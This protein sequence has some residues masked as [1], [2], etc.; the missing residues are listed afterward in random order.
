MKFL[1]RTSDILRF[2]QSLKRDESQFIVIY[3]RRRIGKSTLI[4]KVLDFS[5]GDL[6]Y[7]ADNTS[8][9]NQR[10]LLSNMVADVIEGFN[11][12][13]YPNWE[14]FFRALNRLVPRRI[15][16]C[17]DEFPYMVKTCPSLPSTL[18]KLLD[19][20]S[21]NFDLIICGSSQQLMQGLVLDS[22]E[23]LY[24]RANEII[25][26]APIPPQFI[27][28]ALNCNA[29]T[30]VEEYAVWGGIPRY[31]ELRNDYPDL[32]SAI[33]NILFSPQGVLVDEPQRL[34]R[35]DMRDTVQTSTIMTVIGNG[36][37]R[38]S[39]I[40]ARTGKDTNHITEPIGK[41]KD[42]GY[43]YRDLPWGEDE[44]KSKKGLYKIS[45]PFLAFHFRFVVPYRSYIEIQRGETVMNIV[46]S[47][48]NEHVGDIWE[49]LCRNYVSGNTVNG[50][51]YQ[52]A[53]RWW[54]KV[55]T[56]ETNK[57]GAMVELDVVAES[58]DKKHILIGECKWTA[59]EDAARLIH[60][61]ESI[62]KGLPFVKKHS[63]HYVLFLK[64]KPLHDDVGDIL[65][66][67]DIM[68][69]SPALR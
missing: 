5:R 66:P 31:W 29:V 30:A 17:L 22:R 35:D 47:H 11:S 3:G 63:I 42:L 14:V 12:V 57:D 28:E 43:I 39:E 37:N 41:L 33:N 9:T 25:R 62:A 45:D 15:T 20:K 32:W 19:E 61:L 36:A 10:T 44:K 69:A 56:D 55:I 16:L 60:K 46:K 68:N 52:M 8:K 40:A 4:R 53:R 21:L 54:G 23:P 58:F 64:S 1:D 6:Y 65:Y 27:M 50:I 7:L 38:I 48:F 59:Q 24:G 34:L 18:Q 26:L 67:D 2:Q 49:Q 51:T 13:S